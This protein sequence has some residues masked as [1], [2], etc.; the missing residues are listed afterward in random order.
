MDKENDSETLTGWARLVESTQKPKFPRIVDNLYFPVSRALPSYSSV[1]YG[2]L[3]VSYQFLTP[4]ETPITSP[5][6]PRSAP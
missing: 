5:L 2:R 6:T 3:R 4:D 1:Y